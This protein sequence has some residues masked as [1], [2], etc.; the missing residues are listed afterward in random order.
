MVKITFQLICLLASLGLYAQGEPLIRV[1]PE[2]LFKDSPLQK[3]P[4]ALPKSS[5]GSKEIFRE[6]N[7][8]GPVFYP[9][10]ARYSHATPYGLVYI[11]PE[12]N[13]P[14]LKPYTN[15]Q[16]MPGT[17][18]NEGQFNTKEGS[19]PNGLQLR[20]KIFEKPPVP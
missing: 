14:M 13:M 16:P 15:N 18:D 4:L 2:K 9:D 10:T 1:N 8:G 19:I 11:L 5:S 20:G 17:A 3:K 12:S 6:V 7:P